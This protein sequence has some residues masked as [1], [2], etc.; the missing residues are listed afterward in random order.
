VSSAPCDAR[1]T[2]TPPPIRARP[3]STATRTAEGQGHAAG[4]YQK[5]RGPRKEDVQALERPRLGSRALGVAPPLWK[6]RLPG[7]NEFA[8]N[9]ALAD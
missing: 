8:M 1:T 9:S 2:R 4:Y 6:K 3:R 7:G 5:G